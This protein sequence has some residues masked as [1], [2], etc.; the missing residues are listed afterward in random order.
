MAN[1]IIN[2]NGKASTYL[3]MILLTLQPMS[4]QFKLTLNNERSNASMNNENEATY[5]FVFKAFHDGKSPLVLP[6]L[7]YEPRDR[8]AV[9]AVHIAGFKELVVEFGDG[10][11][12]ILS[13][14]VDDDCVNHDL[15]CELFWYCDF[16]SDGVGLGM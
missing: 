5:T 13:V 1:S 8:L 7:H 6:I 12:G 10:I 2:H 4:D 16:G 9:F 11:R 15:Y 14:E 3:K